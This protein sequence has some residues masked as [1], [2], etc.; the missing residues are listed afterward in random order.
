MSLITR[1]LIVDDLSPS[2]EWLRAAVA[3][4]FPEAVLLEAASILS[5]QAH[6]SPPPDLAL[7]DL[8][9]PDGSGVAIIKA[10]R[11]KHPS[12]WCVV[13]T[14]FDDDAHL[15]GALHAGAQGYV[16]KDETKE[17][18]VELLTGIVND[19][20][21]LSPSIARRLLRHFAAPVEIE[22]PLTDRESEVLRLIGK[23]LSVPAVAEL[24]A[25]SKN[26]VAGYVKEVYR[27]LQIS[28]RA[29][30]ALE[31]AK[32]GFIGRA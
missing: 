26:T 12:A 32:R 6:L 30:A 21:P 10:L 27:K 5:A 7:I 11:A 13:A 24:L 23:G 4:A 14:V 20:P 28:S 22:V 17:N 8:G 2:R 25:L 16:L 1:A 18:L 15:F 29:E 19:R 9:L 31:A 3:Q